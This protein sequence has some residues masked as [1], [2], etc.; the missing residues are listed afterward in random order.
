[1]PSNKLGEGNRPVFNPATEPVYI[2]KRK[3]P[4]GIFTWGSYQTARDE[5][6]IWLFTPRGSLFRGERLGET[7]YCNV[8]SPEGAG[9][10]VMHLVHPGAWWLATFW[11]RGETPWSLTFDLCRPPVFGELGWSYVD[12]ELDI[13]VDSQTQSAHLEDEDEFAEAVSTGTITSDEAARVELAVTEVHALVTRAGFVETGAAR[14]IDAQRQS[15]PPIRRL[16]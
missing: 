5:L 8:G 3:R 7:S 14:L 12:L 13:W 4:E 11:S 10:P 16:P 15:L 6:G 1:M 9:I 2:R